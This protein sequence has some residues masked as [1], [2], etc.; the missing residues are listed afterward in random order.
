MNLPHICLLAYTM[1]A[2]AP[3]MQALSVTCLELSCPVL[4]CPVHSCPV[5]SCPVLSRPLPCPHML[6]AQATQL[7]EQQLPGI[8]TAVSFHP[9]D[10]GQ[11]CCHGADWAAALTFSRLWQ[12]Y[13]VTA[14]KLQLQGHTPTCHTWGPEVGAPDSWRGGAKQ[15][16]V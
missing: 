7:A 9:A 14:Q 15:L 13:S 16:A 10:E 3:H 6:C 12:G 2:G 4:S 1:P 11:L 5:H 8:A